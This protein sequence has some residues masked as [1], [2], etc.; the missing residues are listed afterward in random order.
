[1]EADSVLPTGGADRA[2]KRANQRG[3]GKQNKPNDRNKRDLD[4]E[5][6][7]QPVPDDVV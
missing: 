4:V 1:L 7:Y 6:S 5:I 2:V 3:A